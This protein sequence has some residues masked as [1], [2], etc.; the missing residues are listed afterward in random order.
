MFVWVVLAVFAR[1]GL[2][3]F[4]WDGLAVSIGDVLL[5]F[6]RVF[7]LVFRRVDQLLFVLGFNSS[8]AFRLTNSSS[9][10]L[11]TEGIPSVSGQARSNFVTSFSFSGCGDFSADSRVEVRDDV[12][13]QG[14]IR[15]QRDW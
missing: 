1:V 4:A 2:T 3:V 12:G 9:M 6:A 5:V 7:L 10:A 8:A 14:D 11:S 15:A 13:C